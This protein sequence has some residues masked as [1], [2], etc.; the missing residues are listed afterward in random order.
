MA[1]DYPLFA[2]INANTNLVSKFQIFSVRNI[3][4]SL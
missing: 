4:K 1:V 2:S 3:D